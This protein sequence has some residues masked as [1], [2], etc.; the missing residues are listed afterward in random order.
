M[1]N[2][3]WRHILTPP[4]PFIFTLMDQV[5]HLDLQTIFQYRCR[6]NI[7]KPN[8]KHCTLY[9][10]YIIHCTLYEVRCTM[11]T[12]VNC[13]IFFYRVSPIIT[14]STLAFFLADDFSKAKTL[15]HQ[16]TTWQASSV[17]L[18]LCNARRHSTYELYNSKVLRFVV[19]R[20]K[21]THTHTYIYIY[22]T[23]RILYIM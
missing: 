22:S 2:T 20:K 21:Y 18:W 3:R 19:L 15:S 7:W 11:S 14:Y 8:T 16:G 1:H 10:V 9:T 13:E 12:L 5:L 23:C 4:L 17:V 6:V